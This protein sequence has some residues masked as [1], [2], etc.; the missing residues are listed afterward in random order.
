MSRY[1]EVISCIHPMNLI[2]KII[3]LI[4][5][6]YN[7]ISEWQKGVKA[8]CVE[9]SVARRPRRQV[10]FLTAS[11]AAPLFFFDDRVE[12]EKLGVSIADAFCLAGE[13]T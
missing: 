2:K 9:K 13:N 12:S 1:K 6:L 3:I 11:N 4:N 7:I 8:N 10:L 5:M